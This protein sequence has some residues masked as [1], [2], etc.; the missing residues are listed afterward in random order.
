MLRVGGTVE[1]QEWGQRRCF[2]GQVVVDSRKGA[3]EP[4]HGS[5]MEPKG[6]HLNRWLETRQ[7]QSRSSVCV[8]NPITRGVGGPL[9][10]SWRQ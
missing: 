9:F 6:H 2:P 7:R 1:R 8:E 3:L 5:S 10:P 4:R